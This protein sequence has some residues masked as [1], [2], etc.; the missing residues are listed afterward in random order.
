MLRRDRSQP[1]QL[2]HRYVGEVVVL[3]VVVLEAHVRV[4]RGAKVVGWRVEGD[5]RL[6]AA[7]LAQVRAGPDEVEVE[8]AQ[9]H[10][11]RHQVHTQGSCG[12]G[13][14]REGRH[15]QPASQR[16]GGLQ[17]ERAPHGRVGDGAAQCTSEVAREDG[18]GEGVHRHSRRLE[19]ALADA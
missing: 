1:G 13:L 9:P 10:E 8:R 11:L 6:A 12:A 17:G 5:G 7:R 15:E 2:I 3:D 4:E 16:G 14:H 19:R 18:R